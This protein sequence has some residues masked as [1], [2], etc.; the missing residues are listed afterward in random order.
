MRSCARTSRGSSFALGPSAFEA[1]ASQVA[2]SM[3]EREDVDFGACDLVEEAVPLNEQL[4][5]IGL[6]EFWNDSA[7]LAENIE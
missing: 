5:D 3:N 7:T 4:S 2:R 6:V 1:G